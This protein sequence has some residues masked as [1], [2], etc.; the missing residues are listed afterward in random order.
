MKTNG[1]DKNQTASVPVKNNGTLAKN[2]GAPTANKPAEPRDSI[3]RTGSQ[4]V[5]FLQLVEGKTIKAVAQIFGGSLF[6]DGRPLRDDG[7]VTSLQLFR[8]L[9]IEAHQQGLGVLTLT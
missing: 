8:E 2:G 5:F 9:L 6:S 1:N 3:K 4:D 7:E